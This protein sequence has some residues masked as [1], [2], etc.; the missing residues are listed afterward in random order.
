MKQTWA[1]KWAVTRAVMPNIR[2]GRSIP[3]TCT[4]RLPSQERAKLKRE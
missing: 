2:V 4:M 3:A 1:M